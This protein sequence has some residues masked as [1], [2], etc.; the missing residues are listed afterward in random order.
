MGWLLGQKVLSMIE[1]VVLLY[2]RSCQI[3]ILCASSSEHGLDSDE[4]EVKVEMDNIIDE[5]FDDDSD[6]DNE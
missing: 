3:D 4:D 2:N 6:D 5:I 1:P